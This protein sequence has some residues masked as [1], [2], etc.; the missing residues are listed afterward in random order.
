MDF[1][2]VT[3]FCFSQIKHRAVEV[4]IPEFGL[5]RLSNAAPGIQEYAAKKSK[6]AIKF[7]SSREQ[8][9]SVV[10]LKL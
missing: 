1:D 9:K 3:V 4:E 2:G 6:L 7:V 8:R 10:R 5:Q